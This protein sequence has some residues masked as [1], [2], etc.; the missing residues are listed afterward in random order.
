ML[1]APGNRPDVVAKAL[2]SEA[3]AVIIDLEDAVPEAS[4]AAARES[5]AQLDNQA[6][7][8]YI[9]VNA[10][11]TAYHWADLIAA[12]GAGVAG[13]MVPKAD[14]PR[15]LRAIDAALT[16]LEVEHGRPANSI[17]ILPLLENGRAFLR[18]HK[19]LAASPRI[20]A[21]MFSGGEQGDLVTDLDCEWTPDG[22]ALLTAR[23]LLILAVRSADLDQALDGVFMNLTDLDALRAECE[24][25]RRLG[26]AGKAAI[27]P[28]Q[29]PV[30]H[31]VFTPT[32]AEV[33]AQERML[34]VFDRAVTAGSASLAVDGQM[35][36][37]ATAARARRIL[38]R[39]AAVRR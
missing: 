17:H 32:T 4:K 31:E 1:F 36:D 8:V 29:L 5:L 33:A 7:P 13:V 28:K 24:L 26:Y 39:A 11:G 6:R 25:A 21:A 2:A 20:R 35:V 14:D 38:A 15:A 27:H 19:L 22:T 37:Y 10:S 3:D 18:V 30:I 34:E 9:R 23:S 12:V 16:V